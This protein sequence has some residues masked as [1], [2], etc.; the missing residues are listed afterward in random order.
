LFIFSQ[1]YHSIHT[2]VRHCNSLL[3]ADVRS[4]A[5][6][7]LLT[8][9]LTLYSLL[10]CR[11]LQKQKLIRWSAYWLFWIIL[12]SLSHCSYCPSL[13]KI[14]VRFLSRHNMTV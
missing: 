11:W 8:H 14:T 1:F 9:S 12:S 10:K 5:V 6:K 3:C 2:T 4:C 7:K 13:L